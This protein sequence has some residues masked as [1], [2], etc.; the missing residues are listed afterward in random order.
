M[1]Q[2]PPSPPYRKEGLHLS[3]CLPL[4]SGEGENEK[5]QK[6]RF[7]V[8]FGK[9]GRRLILFDAAYAKRWVLGRGIQDFV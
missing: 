8:G 3:P 6:P 2:P 4:P 5:S 7:F 9:A 1:A